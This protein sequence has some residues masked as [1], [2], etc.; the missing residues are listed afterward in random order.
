[1]AP[2]CKGHDTHTQG[3][4]YF[5]LLDR[6]LSFEVSKLTFVHDRKENSKASANTVHIIRGIY[7]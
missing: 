2:I 5:G 3:P 4:T 6:V 7:H 1:V